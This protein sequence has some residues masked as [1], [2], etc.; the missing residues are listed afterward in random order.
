MIRM[1]SSFYTSG[2]AKLSRLSTEAADVKY[3]NLKC[4]L[5]LPMLDVKG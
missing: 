2:A 5:W 4:S 3:D 1:P